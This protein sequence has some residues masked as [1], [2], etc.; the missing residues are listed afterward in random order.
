MFRRMS[1]IFMYSTIPS[2][3][4]DN[5]M[6]DPGWETLSAIDY[7][8]I[9]HLYVKKCSKLYGLKHFQNLLK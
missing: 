4:P 8:S 2:V 1:V 7:M 6:R 5:V 9:F 3:A